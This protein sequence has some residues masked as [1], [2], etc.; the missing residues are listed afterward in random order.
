MQPELIPSF[1]LSPLILPTC[2]SGNFTPTVTIKNGTLSGVYNAAY[3]QDFFLG[4]PY[5]APPI[6][7][8]RFRRPEPS[9]PWEGVR[10]AV[11]YSNWCMGINMNIV[12][13]SQ[14][15]TGPMS[16]DCLYINIVRPT[17]TPP[18][19]KL[20]VMAWIHGGAYLEGSAN[21]PRYNGSFLV[22][23]AEEM[24]TPII[25][26]SLNYRL[27]TFATLFMGDAFFG[28]GRRA[29]NRAWAAHGV[30][31]YA[32]TFDAQTANLDPRLYGTAH[33]QEIPFVFGNDRGVGFE[34]NPIP[35]SDARYARLAKIMSEM[36]ISFA[37]THSPNNHHL[38]YVKPK[39]PVYSKT[40]R[41]TLWFSLDDVQERPDTSRQEA[42][43]I[44]SESWAVQN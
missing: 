20:P 36:W 32:Y 7:D 19:A 44:Y 3:Q 38:P 40:A 14:D 29:T 22:R 33:F 8:R 2:M 42:Y 11:T 12:G 41:T 27:G 9:L 18:E 37:V 30:P 23:N 43:D 24:G 21:D 34:V 10:S 16:E 1:I 15:P 26:A 25:F 35:P 28:F 5:A 31:S 39:W 6:G 17:N 13:F 4:V